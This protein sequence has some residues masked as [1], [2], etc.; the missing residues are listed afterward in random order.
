MSPN[1]E[2]T[3]APRRRLYG[4]FA[5]YAVLIVVALAVLE[6]RFL[7]FILFFLGALALKSWVAYKKDV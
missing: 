7:A 2:P 6:G 4:A 1:E 3:A 5:G